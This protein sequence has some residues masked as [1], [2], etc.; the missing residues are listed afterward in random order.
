MGRALGGMG[1]AR[2]STARSLALSRTPHIAGKLLTR[3]RVGPCFI[4]PHG[5]RQMFSPVDSLVG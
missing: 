2:S 5:G 4:G 3:L 1:G